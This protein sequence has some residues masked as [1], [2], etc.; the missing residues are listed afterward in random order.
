MTDAIE[1]TEQELQ[2]RLEEWQRRLRLQDWDIKVEVVAG[3]DMDVAN[4]YGHV[5]WNMHSKYADIKLI[6]PDDA[7]R[8]N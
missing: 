2:M 4:C 3:L 8:L 1:P 5:K 7:K 6:N